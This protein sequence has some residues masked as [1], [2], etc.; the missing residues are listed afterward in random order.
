MGLKHAPVCKDR[1]YAP[2]VFISCGQQ[3]LVQSQILF[4]ERQYFVKHLRGIALSS[5]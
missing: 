1:F 3:H 4:A 5:L 2:N